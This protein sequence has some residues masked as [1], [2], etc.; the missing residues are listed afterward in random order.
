MVVYRIS[1]LFRSVGHRVKT[2]KVTPAVGNERGD[3]EIGKYIVLPRG[4]DNR[5]PPRP[6]LV[7]FTMT[8]DRFGHSNLHTNGKLTHCLRSTGAPQSDDVLNKDTRIKNNHY[9]QN[10]DEL[11][12]PVVFMVAAGISSGRINEEF[13]HLLF[14]HANREASAL[15]YTR[16][17]CQPYIILF[18]NVRTNN[19]EGIRHCDHKISS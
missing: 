1:S 8:H 9:L 7:D 4:Q 17:Y 6:L 15:G 12:E 11:P 13:L 2:H 14:L 16:L 3:I 5:L 18:L 19:S 10:Y